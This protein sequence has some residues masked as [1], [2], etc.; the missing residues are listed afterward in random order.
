MA[1]LEGAKAA[2]LVTDGRPALPHGSAGRSASCPSRSASGRLCPAISWAACGTPLIGLFVYAAAQA[3]YQQV[4]IRE[5]LR[6]VPVRRIMTGQCGRRAGGISVAELI[7]DYVY[8]H[9]HSMFPVVDNGRL[10][11]CVSMHD[12]KRLPRDRWSAVK[13]AEISAAVLGI[14]RGKSGYRCHGGALAHDPE[15]PVTEGDGL[16]GIVLSGHRRTS[17]YSS[18]SKIRNERSQ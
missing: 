11:G 10:V 17:R 4:V 14:D 15:L 12:I 7:D 1:N 9:H 13:I 16:V 2:I 8:R 3:S 6:G 18:N 5:G